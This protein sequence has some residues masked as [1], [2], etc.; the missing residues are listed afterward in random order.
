MSVRAKKH[1]GQ[2]FL[3][4][5]TVA[6]NIANLVK[7]TSSDIILEIGPGTGVLTQ[8]LNHFGS[9]LHLVEIDTESVDY[10][11]VHYLGLSDRIIEK[12][13]L[14]INLSELFPDQSLTLVGNYPYNISTQIVFKML[15]YRDMIPEMAGM[16]QKEVAERICAQPGSKVYGILSVLTQAFYECQ[17]AFTVPP[18][19]FNPPPRVES[20]VIYLKRKVNF[21]LKCDEILFFK[22]V[23]TAFQ[24]RRKTLRNSL[25]TFKMSDKLKEDIIFEKRPEQLSVEEFIALTLLLQSDI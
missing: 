15:S 13:I 6:Q 4:D 7:D 24:Q 3:T 5:Q 14:K 18:H 1:L 22:V 2:H 17:Y 10:L 19:V 25:K 8:Y 21:S 23:K 16:F 12:D 20:G 9:K 11:K